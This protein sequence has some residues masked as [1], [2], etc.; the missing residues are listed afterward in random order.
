MYMSK[1]SHVALLPKHRKSLESNKIETESQIRRQGQ[2][3]SAIL[4]DAFKVRF[5]ELSLLYFNCYFLKQKII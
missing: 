2:L 1:L 4:F 3:H 5:T